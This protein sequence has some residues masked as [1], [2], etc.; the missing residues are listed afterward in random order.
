MTHPDWSNYPERLYA[1]EWYYLFL[2][3]DGRHGLTW[4]NRFK[5]VSSLTEL[6]N[7]YSSGEEVAKNRTVNTD[8]YALDLVSFQDELG[9]KGSPMTGENAWNLQELLK[10]RVTAREIANIYLEL[11]PTT[12]PGALLD[13]AMALN[14]VR[15]G[16][17]IGSQYGGWGFNSA[18]DYSGGI[19]QIVTEEG[20]YDVYVPEHR[21]Q[22]EET[23]SISAADMQTKPFFLP[24]FDTRLY[25]SDGSAAASEWTTRT[26]L[27]AE[28]VPARTFAAGA[29][30]LIKKN[31]S[32]IP[33]ANFDMNDAFQKRG[34]PT[35]RVNSL[36]Q[37]RWLHSDW[38]DIPY[39]YNGM[40]F[41]AFVELEG[42]R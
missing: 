39:L 14:G 32:P 28:D 37:S 11:N 21:R 3:T 8:P 30:A 10:G 18:W 34:W 33:V 23:I 42:G 9:N 38:H 40:I 19:Q 29:N 31:S 36:K 16:N 7:F 5:D 13:L 2:D 20:L 17:I 4:R 22:P 15:A 24:F 12:I 26:R 1:S 41:D 6:Y 35:E 25:Q 27:L